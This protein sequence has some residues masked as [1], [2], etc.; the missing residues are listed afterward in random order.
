MATVTT[1]RVV[2]GINPEPM[3]APL[4]FAHYPLTEKEAEA[5]EKSIRDG[6]FKAYADTKFSAV[7]RDLNRVSVSMK[8]N[9]GTKDGKVQTLSLS[10]GTLSTSGYDDQKAMNIVELIKPVISKPTY[11]VEETKVSILSNAD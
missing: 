8:L 3:K 6:K 4:G 9:N 2:E 7:V 10:L 11:N 1:A 5:W